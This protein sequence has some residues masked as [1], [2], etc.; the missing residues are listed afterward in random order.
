MA[1]LFPSDEW[2]KELMTRVNNSSAYQKAAEKWEGDLLFVIEKGPG[3]PEDAYLYM[4]LWH[5][6]CRSAAQ[7][8][9]TSTSSEFEIRAPLPTWQQVLDGKLDPIRGLTTRRLRLKGNLMK[10][11]KSPR[12]A[13]ALV[14][15][16]RRIETT[17][18]R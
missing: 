8:D 17:Y 1:Y 15:C 6:A 5:G 13:L 16:A 7:V 4:D 11:M 3:L 2:V 10:I 12:A 9:A 18:P 14:D